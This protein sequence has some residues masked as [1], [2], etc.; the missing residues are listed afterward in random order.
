M[1]IWKRVRWKRRTNFSVSKIRR[2]ERQICYRFRDPAILERALRHRSSLQRDNL[3]ASEA[4]ELLEFL[5]DA[6]LGMVTAEYLYHNYP[7][8]NEG[9]LTQKKS[10]I[11]SGSVLSK[12]AANLELGEYIIMGAGEARNGGRKRPTILED[13]FEAMVGAIYLDGG[14]KAARN[15]IKN[16]LLSNIDDIIESHSNYKSILLEWTQK[17]FSIQPTY[18]TIKESG[19]DHRKI[20]TVQTQVHN[21][22]GI[23]VGSSKKSAEQNAAKDL[24]LKMGIIDRD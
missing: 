17:I 14:L 19:P 22:Y 9:E 12:C 23:G 2:L 1:C 24:L 20:F 7:E 10:L 4:N 5:G 6:I 13:T 16:V 15:F 8:D 11:V 21:H 3:E 18:K